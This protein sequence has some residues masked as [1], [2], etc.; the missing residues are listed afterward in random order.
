VA[1][2]ALYRRIDRTL[3]F[4]SAI[5]GVQ[6]SATATALPGIP[7][8]W[9]QWTLQLSGAGLDSGA[10]VI[11]D[12]RFVS[13]DY[14][15]TMRIPMMAGEG[16]PSPAPA[17]PGAVPAQHM[18]VLV[19]R[20]FAERYLAGSPGPGRQI[21]GVANLPP[22]EIRGIVGD[23]RE[24]GLNRQPFPTV[25][26]CISAPGPTPFFLIRTGVEPSAM[27]GTIRR[28]LREID[29]AR[30]VFDIGPLTGKMNDAVAENRLRTLLLSVFAATA[31]LLAC[32]GVYSTLSYLVVVKRR[33][34]GLRVALGAERGAIVRHFFGRGLAVTGVSCAVGLVLALAFTRLL[35][36][37][38][39]GVSAS[40]P[41]TLAAVLVLVFA[42]GSAASL[43][44]A[45]RAARVDPMKVLRDE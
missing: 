41:V 21:R 24:G 22:G 17:V 5:P 8:P 16:C 7:A 27:I 32:V 31:I 44:P 2:P 34:I 3:E 11:A 29:P 10:K 35:A 43:A 33:E 14:F 40:D 37:M 4:L 13:P 25:Y 28:K 12:N 15:A 39:Y 30:S 6:A 45:V 20:S 1:Y 23:A 42:V 36:G 9:L 18:D 38:L 19:N 26:W